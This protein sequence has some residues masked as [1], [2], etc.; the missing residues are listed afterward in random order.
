[1][2]LRSPRWRS[3]NA[4]QPGAGGGVL[5]ADGGGL[6]FELLQLLPLGFQGLFALG[7]QA[8]LLFHGGAI[9]LALRGRFF[10]VAAQALQFQAR[11]GEA[12]I[13]ARKIVAQLAHFVIERHAVFL[14][15]LLQRAQTF[16][17]GF[18]RDDLLLQRIRVDCVA[19]VESALPRS[20]SLDAEFARFALHGQRSGRR[21]LAAGDGVAV[22]ADAIGQAGNRGADRQIERRCAAARS[23]ARKHS[24]TRGSRS[25]ARSR[26]PLVRRSES[27]RRAGDAGFGADGRLGQRRLS[28]PHRVRDA[29]GRWRGH[30]VRRG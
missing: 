15:R 4:G 1:M 17:F 3:S 25:V 29:P 19:F 14:A 12:R 27:L 28:R 21:F 22:V 9:G 11:H 23:S 8:I 26:K 20:A 16:Q 5:F 10:G 24:E 7:A 13:G 30:R 2:A 6:R 18:E